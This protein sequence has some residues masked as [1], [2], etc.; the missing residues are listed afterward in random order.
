MRTYGVGE[1]LFAGL[2]AAEIPV[3]GFRQRTGGGTAAVR[4]QGV[5]VEGVIPDLRRVIENAAAAGLDQLFQGSVRFRLPFH[6]RVQLVDVSLVML[7]VVKVDG[8]SA[9]V[10]REGITGVGQSGQLKSH[11]MT[12]C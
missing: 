12:P 2:K 7:T 10:G 9:D 4:R 5:P 8:L 11:G 1:G 3:D 6:R